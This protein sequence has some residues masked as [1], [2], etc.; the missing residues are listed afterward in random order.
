[1]PK[2]PIPEQFNTLLASAVPGHLA[3]IG[4]DG[5]PQVNPVWFLWHGGQLLLSVKAETVKYRNLRRN[6]ALAMSIVDP[7]DAHRYLELRGKV[8][9]FTLYLTLDFVDLLARKYTGE[10]MDPAQNGQERYKLTVAIESW[11]G[12]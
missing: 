8:I 7:D 3:T 9:G 12:T 10:A 1:M 11:T 4:A 6:P 2:G 5:N